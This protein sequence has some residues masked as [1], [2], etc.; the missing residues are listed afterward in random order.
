[1]K[2]PVKFTAALPAVLQEG[3]KFIK[4]HG[5]GY[6]EITEPPYVNPAIAA[7]QKKLGKRVKYTKTLEYRDGKAFVIF[8][9]EGI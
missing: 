9:S 5:G 1:M 4:V 3:H 8:K 2:A 7:L 6:A